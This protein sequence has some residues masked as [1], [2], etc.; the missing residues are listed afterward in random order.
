M[1][2]TLTLSSGLDTLSNAM[3]AVWNYK[4]SPISDA[5]ASQAIGLVRA[6]LQLAIQTPDD[7]KL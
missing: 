6:N 4:H 7:I 5:L 2:D 1:P 3:E